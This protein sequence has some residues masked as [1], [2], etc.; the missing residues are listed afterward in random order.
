MIK[1]VSK[2][3]THQ[4]IG[5]KEFIIDDKVTA[6]LTYSEVYEKGTMGN[7]A[8]LN[9]ILRRPDFLSDEFKHKHKLYYGH[10]DGLG[11]I[12]ADDELEDL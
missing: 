9:F 10:V 8:C 6:D 12:V 4:D 3:V 7:P 1:R 11:Y 5:G 2:K